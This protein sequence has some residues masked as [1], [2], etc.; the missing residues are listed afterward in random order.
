[1]CCRKFSYPKKTCRKKSQNFAT[2]LLR[3][4]TCLLRR[5]TCRKKM[6]YVAK[7]CDMSQ[8]IAKSLCTSQKI[9]KQDRKPQTAPNNHGGSGFLYLAPSISPLAPLSTFKSQRKCDGTMDR[10]TVI[11]ATKS[12]HSISQLAQRCGCS[13]LASVHS[14]SMHPSSQAPPTISADA[15]PTGHGCQQSVDRLAG[16]FTRWREWRIGS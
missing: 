13:S 4:A 15:N 10:R 3:R 1:M 11:F 16:G 8:K 2:C 14:S 5:V 12:P 7:F 9:A 6:R